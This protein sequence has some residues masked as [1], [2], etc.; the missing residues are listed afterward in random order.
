MKKLK[1]NLPKFFF[2]FLVIIVTVGFLEII[3]EF[4]LAVFWAVVLAILFR[5]GYEKFLEKTGNR[6]NLAAGITVLFILLLGILP[7]TGAVVALV[8]QVDDLVTLPDQSS[9]TL[10]KV[11]LKP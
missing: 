10:K 6:P 9:D 2:L 5:K 8:D 4:L 11:P 7:I 3:Q 1:L